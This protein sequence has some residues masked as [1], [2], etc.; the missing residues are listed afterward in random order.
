MYNVRSVWKVDEHVNREF[1]SVGKAVAYLST[2]KVPAR[3]LS[4]TNY[5]YVDK[6]LIEQLKGIQ[7]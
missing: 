4:D 6:G 1:T 7:E 3:V 5:T 2:V